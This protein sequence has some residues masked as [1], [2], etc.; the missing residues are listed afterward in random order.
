M[1]RVLLVVQIQKM[2]GVGE[3]I[4]LL[5]HVKRSP[6]AILKPLIDDVNYTLKRGPDWPVIRHTQ[7]GSAIL[8]LTE[9][10]PSP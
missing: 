8:N 9:I 7:I 6:Q 4:L 3:S 10:G 5:F 1:R 2:N